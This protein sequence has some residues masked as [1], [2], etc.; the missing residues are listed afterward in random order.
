MKKNN[1]KK[2]FV[3]LF[4]VLYLE[5]L[6]HFVIFKT[7]SVKEIFYIILFCIVFTLLIDIITSLFPKTA[8]KWILIVLLCFLPFLFICQY[9]NFLFYGNIISIYSFIHGGQVLE[10]FGA[11]KQAI[12]NNIFTMILFVL[13]IPIL[14]IFN[15]RIPAYR[16]NYK[17]IIAKLILF[18]IIFII[19][20]LSLNLDKKEIYSAKNL[21]YYK[22][23]PNSSAQTFGILTTMGLDLERIITNFEEKVVVNNPSNNNKN[24]EPINKVVE[25]NKTDIDFNA[26]AENESNSKIKSIHTYM[27]NETP[28]E[29]NKYTGMFKGKNLIAIVAEA[30]YPIAIDENITPTLYKLTH[31]GFH[32]TN[33]YTPLYYVSTSDGEYSTLN[34]LIPKEGVWS[35]Y[36]SRNNLLPYAYGNVFSKLGYTANAYHNG[37][38]KYYDRNLSHP[39][40]GYNYMGCGNG[41][42]KLM[43]CKPWP[44]SDVEMINA[45][46]NLYADKTPFVTY[47][48]TISGHLEYNFMGN[49]MAYRHR[50]EVADLPY[51]EAI[52]A[53]YAT[54]IELDKALESLINQLEEK[55][56]L[57]DTVIVLSADHYP[58]G[59][60]NDQ[61]KEVLDIEDE[62]FDIHKNNLIIWNNNIEYTEID[63]YAMSL[64][65]LPTVLNLFGVDYDSRLLM[66]RDI[67]SNYD[68]LVI[69]NDRSW[70][71]E[72][73]KYNAAKK[74]FT[75][76]KELDDENYVEKINEIVYNKFVISKNILEND[77]YRKVFKGE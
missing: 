7:I 47:Y 8:N 65:I 20:L 4:I 46:V 22:H 11:I 28:S 69:F 37:R 31:E 1:L 56:I 24:D 43:N 26:L 62:K 9:I 49:N 45:T 59:L 71:T 30:F 76:F 10:F 19:S 2:Y 64:D 55:G 27:A 36:V 38:Y 16:C 15:K 3:S 18:I 25:Y 35:F 42:E 54:H 75:P 73:G 52:R 74:V 66:G 41:L 67:L 53:Y 23:V 77:Y 13:P 14:L 6:Y 60:T 17:Q 44:Q 29:K 33:F 61:I 34:S 68:G 39:N 32:F 51:S 40:M 72:Y 21:F 57:D 5:F 63:K 50:S 70:I 12:F 48:M 58:Y